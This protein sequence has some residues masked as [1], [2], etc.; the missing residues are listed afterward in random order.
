MIKKIING[1]FSPMFMGVLF[2]IMA[3]AL[4]IA[5]FIENDYGAAASGEMVYKAW[6][7]ELLFLLSALN[8]TGQI[9]IFKL[10][11]RGKITVFL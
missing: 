2:I 11:R 3:V 10:Y 5:T 8:L 4:A 7:F 9:I 1:L 6:W